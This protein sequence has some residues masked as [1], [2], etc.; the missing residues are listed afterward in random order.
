MDLAGVELFTSGIPRVARMS[1][2]LGTQR[3]DRWRVIPSSDSL[4]HLTDCYLLSEQVAVP[5]VGADASFFSKER[6]DTRLLLSW[7]AT[8]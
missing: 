8:A 6:H 1:R 4:I 7:H 2:I 5:S 3:R